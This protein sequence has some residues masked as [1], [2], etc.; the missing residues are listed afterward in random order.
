MCISQLSKSIKAATTP[1]PEKYE[2]NIKSKGF[3]I[4]QNEQTDE[5]QKITKLLKEMILQTSLSIDY[6]KMLFQQMKERELYEITRI[7]NL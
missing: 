3:Q 1:S 4:H 6:N 5:S 7:N 2:E